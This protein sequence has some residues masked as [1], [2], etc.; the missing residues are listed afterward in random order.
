MTEAL[1]ASNDDFP[2]AE[3]PML[4]RAARGLLENLPADEFCYVGQA[5]D[6]SEITMDGT[7]NLR[8]GARAVIE[9]LMEPSEDMISAGWYEATKRTKKV[10]SDDI[11]LAWQAML[12]AI[13]EDADR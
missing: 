6:L 8:A 3:T 12:K 11:V 9:S 13:L 4:E 7:L 2:K 10:H 5:E 1:K